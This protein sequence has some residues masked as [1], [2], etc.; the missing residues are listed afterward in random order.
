MSEEGAHK[1]VGLVVL[2]MNLNQKQEAKTQEEVV[3]RSIQQQ[4]RCS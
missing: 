2:K 3:E 4:N 1:E